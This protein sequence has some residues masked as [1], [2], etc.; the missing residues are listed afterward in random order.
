MITTRPMP[1][2]KS[3]KA[4]KADQTQKLFEEGNKLYN[5]G[6]IE[7]ALG[8]YEDVLKADPDFVKAWNNKGLALYGLRNYGEARKALETAV[9]INPSLA[10]PWHNLGMVLLALD[11]PREALKA[12]D[13][14][15]GIAPK[16]PEALCNKGN[17]LY[18]IWQ[19]DKH[20]ESPGIY[21]EILN[22]TSDYETEYEDGL[23]EA[24][25][26]YGEALKI[27]PDYAGAW[28]A[29]GVVLLDICHYD[30]ALEAYNEA[31]RIRPDFEDAWH[32]KGATLWHMHELDEAEKCFKKARELR[33]ASAQ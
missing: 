10:A 3:D 19:M 32:N 21:E 1:T 33:D 16:Y 17:A 20:R 7:A 6:K 24:L 9:K 4:E 8:V 14:A 5:Q 18:L 12:F 30:E 28:Y 26:A 11:Q 29:K 23:K 22:T 15:L 27:K 25:E 31:L 2:A 13:V